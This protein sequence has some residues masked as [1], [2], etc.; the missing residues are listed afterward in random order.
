MADGGQIGGGI[1]ETTARF[2]H[3]VSRV[4]AFF[5]FEFRQKHHFGAVRLYRQTTRHQIVYH[6][7]QIVVVIRFTDHIVRREQ[8]A[9]FGIHFFRVLHRRSDKMAP[10]VQYL[11]VATLQFHH[12]VTRGIGKVFVFIETHF[13]IAVEFFQIRQGHVGIAGFLLL[14]QVS[15]QHAKLCA[16]VANVVLRNHF[17]T[18]MAQNAVQAVADD[19]RAQ[20]AHVHFFGQIGR[21]IINHDGLWRSR[22]F[23][24]QT[25]I[26]QCGL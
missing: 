1:Q 26:G 17:V 18:Q 4:F 7:L 3:D 25:R 16:P 23:Y 2:L 6:R 24:A 11:L 15:H 22:S 21:R 9:Q 12:V 20:M 19:G 10:Q 13:G 8:H 14:N 5:V